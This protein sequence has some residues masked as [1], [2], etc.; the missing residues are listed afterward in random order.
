[1]SAK[2]KEDLIAS[3]NKFVEDN[4]ELN[5]SNLIKVIND[6][7]NRN[8]VV[9]EKRPLS[10]YQIFMKEH[11]ASVQEEEKKKGEVKPGQVLSAIGKLWKLQK[12]E[13]KEE[14]K[15]KIEIIDEEEEKKFD[16]EEEKKSDEEEE[17]KSDE[18]IKEEPPKKPSRRTK[19]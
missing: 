3:F 9:K 2:L 5:K 14:K 15:N 11:Y 12:G 7:Y 4:K 8:K 10:A 13:N 19:K 18:E 17:E 1:M 16:E 6:V